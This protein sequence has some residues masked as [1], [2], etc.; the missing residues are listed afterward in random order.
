[1]EIYLS[2]EYSVYNEIVMFNTHVII[3]DSQCLRFIQ[4]PSDTNIL[5]HVLINNTYI[6]K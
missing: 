1:M 4:N 5:T 6:H 3:P 2:Y